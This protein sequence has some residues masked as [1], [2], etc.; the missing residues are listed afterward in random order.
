MRQFALARFEAMP[1]EQ[2]GQSQHDLGHSLDERQRERGW[3]GNSVNRA[4]GD[5]AAFLNADRAGNQESGRPNGVAETLDDE[6]LRHIG[7]N[8]HTRQR[9]PDL[10]SA[11]EPHDEVQY[12]GSRHA[13]DVVMDELDAV[14]KVGGA[15]EAL[16]TGILVELE[17]AAFD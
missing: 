15:G 1:I 11:D 12:E 6:S 16:P 7:L 10:E 8:S 17:Q 4:E 9:H 3:R 5:E 14:V 2:A 13:R